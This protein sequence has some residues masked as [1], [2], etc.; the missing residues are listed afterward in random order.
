MSAERE[1]KPITT[2]SLAW[3]VF[4]G[5]LTTALTIP[6]RSGPVWANDGDLEGGT[7]VSTG[8]PFV[9]KEF[10]EAIRHHLVKRFFYTISADDAQQEKL[11]RLLDER[12]IVTRPMRR[13]L[14]DGF[15]DL[16]KL[17][18][19]GSTSEEAI[20]ARAHQLRDLHDKLC[21]ERLKTVLAVRK[22]LTPAQLKTAGDKLREFMAGARRRPV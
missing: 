4:A 1:R 22:E 6:L 3:G 12:M 5:L 20:T 15:V 18:Q 9:D 10:Q 7:P 19:D 16:I 11:T 8:A 17:V 13:E 21:D 2:H 14:K